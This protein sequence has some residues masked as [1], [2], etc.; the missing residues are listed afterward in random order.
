MTGFYT[1]LEPDILLPYS[2]NSL[3]SGSGP[4][5]GPCFP[6][7][8]AWNLPF[9]SFGPF[10]ENGLVHQSVEV[11]VDLRGKQGPEF[12]VQSLLEHVLLLLVIV[13]FLWCISGQ[14]HE[15]VGVLFY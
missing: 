13:H 12:W 9:F 5:G 2:W 1:A 3:V 15:L 11:R 6:E 10:C 7:T 14:L 8:C 4:A